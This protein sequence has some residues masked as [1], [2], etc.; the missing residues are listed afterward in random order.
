M[1]HYLDLN[2]LY[3]GQGGGSAAN[4]PASP[5]STGYLRMRG[6]EYIRMKAA[7]E[8]NNSGGSMRLP[9][10]TAYADIPR[11]R[12]PS[13]TTRNGNGNIG[14]GGGGRSG[15]WGGGSGAAAA[16]NDTNPGIPLRPIMQRV[17]EEDNHHGSNNGDDLDVVVRSPSTKLPSHHHNHYH[18]RPPSQTATQA[19]GEPKRSSDS[20][21]NS[22]LQSGSEETD[23]Q[24]SPMDP[25]I[26]KMS[27]LNGHGGH[28]RNGKKGCKSNDSVVSD[29]SSG[30][31]SDYIPEDNNSMPPNYEAVIASNLAES[32]V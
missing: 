11:H 7:S 30:F 2:D 8:E 6:S 24:P 20:S 18:H 19:L 13:T 26:P 22:G 31:H 10:S 16:A 9:N 29:A 17:R 5:T 28:L 25:F 1:Q 3:T 21:G 14:G 23:D 4:G 32:N 12:A 27:H 15:G